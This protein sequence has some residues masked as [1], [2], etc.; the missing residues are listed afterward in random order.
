MECI[1]FYNV[2]S[3][4]LSDIAKI[5]STPNTAFRGGGGVHSNSGCRCCSLRHI[6]ERATRGPPLRAFYLTESIQS[7]GPD[8][9]VGLIDNVFENQGAI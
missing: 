3:Q 8:K 2:T 6:S 7:A 9:E 4:N 5:S 1:Y